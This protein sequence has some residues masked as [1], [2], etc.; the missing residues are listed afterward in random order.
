M[1]FEFEGLDEFKKELLQ[2][3]GEEF[4]AEKEKELKKLALMATSQIKPLVPV[5]TGRLVNSV[6]FSPG[7]ATSEPFDGKSEGTILPVDKDTIEITSNV[8]YAS[9]VN[10]GHMVRGVE[11]ADSS[12]YRGI[13]KHNKDKFVKGTHFM[14][15]GLQNAE[16]EIVTEIDNWL[17]K[18]FNKAGD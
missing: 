9:Y 5:D 6:T 14:E 3:A 18:L 4:A 17:N 8:E 2:L 10:N 12:A 7:S 16:P 15:K 11:V 13:R 1:G